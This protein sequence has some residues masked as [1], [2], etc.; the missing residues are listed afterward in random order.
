MDQYAVTHAYGMMRNSIPQIDYAKR[1]TDASMETIFVTLRGSKTPEEICIIYLA[2]VHVESEDVVR[3]L[4]SS[5]EKGKR[6]LGRPDTE[7]AG[8]PWLYV[9]REPIPGFDQSANLL[10]QIRCSD[11]EDTQ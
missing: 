7:Q 3:Q 4:F 10:V 2:F 11:G 5:G 6:Y 9:A 1:I 8:E